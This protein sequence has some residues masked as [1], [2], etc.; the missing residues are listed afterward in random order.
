MT[1]E[2]QIERFLGEAHK[3]G[4]ER[5][6]M[7]SSGN[8]SWRAE[9]DVALVSGTGSWLPALKREDVCVCRV[10]DG[11]IVDGPKPSVE[12]SFHLGVMRNR[13]GVNVVLHFQSQ[14]ATVVAC[15]KEK[16]R[17]FNVTIEVPCYVGEVPT[18]P[19][20]RPGSS[21][22]ADAVTDALVKHNVALLSNH[23]QVAC[24]RDFDE[25]FQ[26]AVFFEMACGII[27]LAG[28]GNYT[29]LSEEDIRGLKKYLMKKEET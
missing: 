9:R 21:E 15:M 22:L 18:L 26:R 12:S 29:T 20:L 11:E 13:P 25:A 3:L 4:A 14:Y 24:G 19:Y 16:P 27:V 28:K 23:G 8:L 17:N 1:R 6:M 7:C 2:E 5:L 10:S